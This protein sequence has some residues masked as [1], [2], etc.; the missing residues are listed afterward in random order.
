M[1][2]A[3]HAHSPSVVTDIA[4]VHTISLPFLLHGMGLLPKLLHSRQCVLRGKEIWEARGKG[5][6]K[7]RE[8]V[9]SEMDGVSCVGDTAVTRRVNHGYVQREKSERKG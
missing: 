1:T 6:L 5:P 8:S 4:K 7:S 2:G 3:S 9:S